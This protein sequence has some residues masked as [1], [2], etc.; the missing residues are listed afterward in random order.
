MVASAPR[1]AGAGGR[2][3]GAVQ[4]AGIQRHKAAGSESVL[5]VGQQRLTGKPAKP[6][7]LNLSCVWR[8][9]MKLYDLNFFYWFWLNGYNGISSNRII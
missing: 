6:F 2:S 4:H 7:L 5:D 1:G 3:G 8:E 9:I